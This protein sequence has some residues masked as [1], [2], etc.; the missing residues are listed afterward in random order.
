VLESGELYTWGSNSHGKLGQGEDDQRGSCSAPRLVQSLEGIPIDHV[1]CGSTFMAAV[2]RDGALYTWG[3]YSTHERH[4]PTLGHDPSSPAVH[5]GR[6]GVSGTPFL[7]VPLRVA[8]LQELRVSQVSCGTEHAAALTDDGR[9]HCWGGGER[10][11][12]GLGN[13]EDSH[14]PQRV[15]ALEDKTVCQLSCGTFHTLGVTT[16]GMVYAW[17]SGKDGKLGLG[18]VAYCPYFERDSSGQPFVSK[19]HLITAL[20]TRNTVVVQA[21][22][23]SAHSAA[24]TASGVVYTFGCGKHGKL[25]HT[26]S[27]S[28]WL[29]KMVEAVRGCDAT[30]V[31]C[32][33]DHTAVVGAE[34]LITWGHGER[35][36]LG[37]GQ[38]SGES[39]PFTVQVCQR[40][41]LG[42]AV[43]VVAAV[44][45]V[46]V[47]VA[48]PGYARPAAAGP[49]R[50][51]SHARARG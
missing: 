21:S 51:L 32:G 3:G 45:N 11:K 25:G 7:S 2:A 6:D 8:A 20:A 48:R 9:V 1:A 16:D 37:N 44:A 40:P 36:R 5:M 29:P 28:E 39:K 46:A 35:G 18:D 15:V 26:G 4:S 42:L 43:C 22:A 50:A 24:V 34:G 23:G 33:R 31:A 17:G 49:V 30:Q 19:P 41:Q 38:S 14:I 27:G 10:G 12:L 47:H 13:E